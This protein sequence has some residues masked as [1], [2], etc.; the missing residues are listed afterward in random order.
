[1]LNYR[2]VGIAT[3][4]KTQ[5]RNTKGEWQFQNMP[6][7]T[8]CNSHRLTRGS[9]PWARAAAGCVTSAPRFDLLS[10]F[11]P[12]LPAGIMTTRPEIPMYHHARSQARATF[13]S[14]RRRRS[15]NSSNRRGRTSA[16]C[17]WVVIISPLILIAFCL[18]IFLGHELVRVPK[19][20]GISIDQGTPH[21]VVLKLRSDVKG[22]GV[23]RPRNLACAVKSLTL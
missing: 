17:W 1:M 13:S 7:Y 4:I 9:P 2:H 23:K 14:T 3:L 20:G 18:G 15:S 19:R 6:I 12:F 5:N 22:N 8:K 11:L 21:L 16:A 10:C